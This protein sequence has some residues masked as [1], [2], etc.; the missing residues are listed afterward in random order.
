MMD[1]GADKLL[2]KPTS[3]KKKKM[4]PQTSVET[5]SY[6]HS[7]LTTLYNWKET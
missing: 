2:G 4:F 7:Y 3:F 5:E 6:P 1:G